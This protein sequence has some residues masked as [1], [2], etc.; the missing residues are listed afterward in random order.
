VNPEL[1]DTQVETYLRRIGLSTDA[2]TLDYAGL[3]LLQRS[4]LLTVSFNN[5][6]VYDHEPV[7]TSLDWSLPSVLEGKGGWCFVLNGAFSALLSSLGFRVTRMAA[8]VMMSPTISPMDDHLCLMVALEDEWLVDVGFGDSFTSP[9]RLNSGEP[10]EDLG[11]A[12][13]FKVT[14]LEDGSNQLESE[15]D[16]G[17]RVDYRFTRRQRSL[18]YFMTANDHLRTAP[19]LLWTEKPF[20]T[21]L[22]PTGRVSLLH[23]RIKHI[24]IEG[25]TET[26]SLNDKASW[27]V[28]QRQY[29]PIPD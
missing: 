18:D 11:A 19:G 26:V 14:T 15:Q 5:L 21:R 9:L 28:A 7:T 3:V 27:K 4:H 22:T 24:P 17:W 12:R 6:D 2:V 23:D 13:R 20:A 29:F 25:P 10:A 8:R 16:D 1:T